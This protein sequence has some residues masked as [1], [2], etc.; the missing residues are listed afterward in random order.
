MLSRDPGM[1]VRPG[2][3]LGMCGTDTGSWLSFLLIQIHLPPSPP[4]PLPSTPAASG[5]NRD[6]WRA[7]AHRTSRQASGLQSSITP[8]PGGSL[9]CQMKTSSHLGRWME[10][11]SASCAAPH[12]IKPPWSETQSLAGSE[13]RPSWLPSATLL[14]A[15]FCE[16]CPLPLHPI[17]TA[18][19]LFTAL[20]PPRAL[21]PKLLSTKT[22]VTCFFRVA[23]PRKAIVDLI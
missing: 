18:C 2:Y 4:N 11:A 3:G 1:R 23:A 17:P 16:L 13:C 21:D 22:Q 19:A 10:Q 5:I 12:A 9:G 8:A 20:R 6:E 7:D 15:G 14:K